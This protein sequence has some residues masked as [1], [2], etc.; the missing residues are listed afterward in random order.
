M[1]LARA[2][3]L[4]ALGRLGEGW[5]E[6]E[7]RFHPQFAEITHFLVDRPRWRPGADLA[8]KTL[9]VVGEQGLGD[10]IL[11]SNCLRDVVDDLGPDGRLVLAVEPRLVAMFQ[12]GFPAATV[13]PHA[14]YALGTRPA[15]AVP[16]LDSLGAIDLWAPIASLLRQYRRSRE[17]FPSTGAWIAA[18]PARVAYWRGRLAELPGRK[19]GL[20]WKSAITKD[21]RHRY[22][23]AFDD[24]GP[25]LTQPGV[26]LVNL[27]YGDCA[28]ELAHARAKFGVEIW[29]PD[30]VDLKQD[31]DEV[32]ALS[33]ALD[34][35]VGF[36]N[37]T[38]NIAAA[39][40]APAW[41]I[42]I[43][44]SWPRLGSP[45]RYAW[46]PQVEVFAAAKQGEW[47]P[48]MARLAEALSRHAAE[49]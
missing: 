9:L 30:G 33:C 38:F 8:G 6:Y 16:E 13:V 40:G 35:V 45:D 25:V 17:A 10:E 11:F 34:L 7:A 49:R 2:T 42:T 24:W 36:S 19:V 14:T 3:S 18:D 47:A 27:Q 29:Q 48:V 4:I 43:P 26:T 46:Y 20:L 41:L 44:G 21:A 39:C 32:A 23:A 1:R 15:R 5:D 12:R 31:L 28:Q 22:F 37:A